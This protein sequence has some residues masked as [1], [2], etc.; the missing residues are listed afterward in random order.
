LPPDDDASARA[1]FETWF[2]A[3]AVAGADGENGLFTGYYEA[4]LHGALHRGGR[5]QTPLYAR[6]HDL[7]TADLGAFKT[8]WKGQHLTGK[9]EGNHFVPYDDR[10]SIAKGS[11]KARAKVL[12]WVDDP[13]DAFFLAVQ[14]SGRV[15]LANNHVLRLGYDQANG[16]AYVAI[17]RALA[18]SGALQRPV[19]MQAIRVYLAAHPDRAAEVMNLNPSYV[20]FRTLK[21]DQPI[22]A[23][24]VELTPLRSLATDPAF[25]ALGS[26]VWL[27]TTDGKG[28]SLQRLMIAQ[29][30]GGAIKG[31]VRGDVFWG[32][33]AD[34]EAQAG[35]MQSRGQ[36]FVLLPKTQDAGP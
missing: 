24:G 5:Y 22:G 23:E 13:A 10:A 29:D 15:R 20:F 35:A 8:E 30:T 34:A 1:F 18:D 17:G 31:A 11:L 6:P 19:T 33:G 9:V 36:Y 28:A 32:Y 21:G 27:D 12:A 4:E 3:Y 26:P 16:R 7:L 25:I 14:G 2:R